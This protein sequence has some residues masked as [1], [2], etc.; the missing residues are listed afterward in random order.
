MTD[1]FTEFQRVILLI[2][3]VVL[4]FLLWN[5]WNEEHPRHKQQA[6]VVEPT[7]VSASESVVDIPTVVNHSVDELAGVPESSAVLPVT[8]KE[9]HWVN[10]K[11][12]V[13]D[14]SID[15]E[16]GGIVEAKL[17]Q[18]PESVDKKNIPVELLNSN[19]GSLYVAQS[20][21]RG[22]KGPDIVEGNQAKVA[23]YQPEA[24]L[25]QLADND[26]VL[27]VDLH[28]KNPE[29][30]DVIKRFT[31]ER[32]SYVINVDHIVKN[33]SN[34]PWLGQY[35][36][37][38]KR[39][40]VEQKSS[41][42]AFPTYFGA[43]VHSPE[44]KFEKVTFSDMDKQPLNQ[45]IQDGWLAMIQHYF[46]TAWI[47]DSN[48]PY[49]YYT[50]TAPHDMYWIGMLSPTISVK[51][52]EKF[53]T[54]SQFYVGP[55][56]TEKL[57]NIAPGL[58]LSVD[59][60]ILWPISSA[61]FWIMKK[62]YALFANWGVAIIGVTFLIKLAFY[63][64]SA[65][66]YRSMA[67]MRRL[68][69]KLTALKE[70]YGSDRQRMSQAMM[71]LY[72]K[73]KIN[74]LGGCLPILVQIPVFI[75]LYWVLIESVELRQAPFIWWIKDLS[76][77]DPY[78]ILP[79]LMGISMY[80]QQ[81]LSPAPPDPMQAKVLMMMPV[82][83]TILFLN[84]PAGLMLYWVFNNVLSIAQQWYVTHTIENNGAKKSSK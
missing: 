72:K 45:K 30:V 38:I 23:H 39:Q 21:L 12:D 70:R 82:V 84:F 42:F 4:G 67:N 33:N 40:K 22:A 20:G 55:S 46:L 59:Y 31:L 73:E 18:Y 7:D 6:S 71:E 15:P 10:V 64:L 3:L 80:V 76:V 75:A 34:E 32:G 44:K 58:E 83:F 48:I 26:N 16:G 61:L 65:S 19:P 60:G 28:W 54:S 50:Y 13:L 81:K 37:Q 24:Y 11:T 43:A 27:S 63:P 79:I 57:A 41:L 5:T 35:F 74:P 47:P 53:K 25:Y 2:V 29:G 9:N 51:P 52:G 49:T 36:S 78:Y 68:Q 62:I 1:K 17:L 14:I 77:K 8:T 66:S 56:V 69:P